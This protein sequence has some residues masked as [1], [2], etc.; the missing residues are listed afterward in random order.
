MTA[1]SATELLTGNA[2]RI[3]ALVRSSRLKHPGK[4]Q[5]GQL[6][7]I[8]GYPDHTLS[9]TNCG[10]RVIPSS[11]WDELLTLKAVNSNDPFLSD[12]V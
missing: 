1:S 7:S 8:V 2:P 4:S 5:G 11:L 10:I 6:S 3:T 9:P 12:I